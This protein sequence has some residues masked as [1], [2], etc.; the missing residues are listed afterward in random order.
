MHKFANEEEARLCL[1]RRLNGAKQGNPFAGSPAVPMH[2]QT[3]TDGG[4]PATEELTTP[5]P[6]A[7]LIIFDGE[8]T[9]GTLQIKLRT[10]KLALQ[11]L[12]WRKRQGRQHGPHWWR[13]RVRAPR[14]TAPATTKTDRKV[15]KKKP[16]AKKK[17]KSQ[18][19]RKSRANATQRERAAG[20]ARR[21]GEGDHRELPVAPPGSKQAEKKGDKQT[22]K[23]AMMTT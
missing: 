14:T 23:Q 7:V 15:Q 11:L 19:R 1:V 10:E 3:H 2:T 18:K 8:A 9:S 16:K 13:M 12:D 22:A 20:M 6:G 17:T 21:A 4:R 5:E